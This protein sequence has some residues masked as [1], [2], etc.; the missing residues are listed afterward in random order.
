[1]GISVEAPPLER[2]RKERNLAV[3]LFPAEVEKVFSLLPELDDP[4]L[5]VASTGR[6]VEEIA[7]LEEAL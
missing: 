1:L 4:L 5:C 6:A 3:P 2:V 7:L